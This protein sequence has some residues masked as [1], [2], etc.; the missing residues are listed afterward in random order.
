ML[1]A[2]SLPGPWRQTDC[3]GMLLMGKRLVPSEGSLRPQA[4]NARFDSGEI[5]PVLSK[6]FLDPWLKRSWKCQA[7]SCLSAWVQMEGWSTIQYYTIHW[8]VRLSKAIGT[9]R[10]VHVS[11]WREWGTRNKPTFTKHSKASACLRSMS[12]RALR[13]LEDDLRCLKHLSRCR[14]FPN[15]LLQDASP[16]KLFSERALRRSNVL[17]RSN[18]SESRNSD[19]S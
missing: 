15:G 7:C 17:L 8:C 1:S 3:S 19:T 5:L 13:N 2:K 12:K 18:A 10:R 11:K 4:R 6:L 9:T 16:P 14:G